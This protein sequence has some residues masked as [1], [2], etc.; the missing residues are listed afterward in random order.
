MKPDQ[1]SLL[2]SGVSIE[3]GNRR[4]L[5]SSSQIMAAYFLY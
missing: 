1:L 5:P 4:I 3:A 2:L